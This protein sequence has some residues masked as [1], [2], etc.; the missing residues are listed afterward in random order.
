MSFVKSSKDITDSSSDSISFF[1]TILEWISFS[2]HCRATHSSYY[3]TFKWYNVN[4]TFFLFAQRSQ[5]FWSQTDKSSSLRTVWF[6]MRATI[7]Q[8]VFALIRMRCVRDNTSDHRIF[9]VPRKDT[10][11]E[12]KTSPC[13]GDSVVNML[14]GPHQR[15]KRERVLTYSHMKAKLGRKKQNSDGIKEAAGKLKTRAIVAGRHQEMVHRPWLCSLT[16]RWCPLT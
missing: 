12:S 11:L 4:T 6:A 3:S 16:G 9:Q 8:H 14:V 13:S 1:N 7:D 10:C 5:R 15:E 2:F